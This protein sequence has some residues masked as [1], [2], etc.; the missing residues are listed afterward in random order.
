MLVYRF[1]VIS[2][3]FEDFS[4]EICI[5]PA[6]TF[7]EFHNCLMETAELLPCEQASFFLTDKKYKKN[8]EI[9]LNPV[10]RQVKRYDEEMDEMVMVKF[11][12]RLMKESKVKDFIEDPHQRLIYEYHGKEYFI[13]LLEL[14]KIMQSDG[15]GIYPKCVKRV[16]EIPKKKETFIVS[17]T[18]DVAKQ[19]DLD[20][21]IL[22]ELDTLSKLD[23]IEENDDELADIEEN[24]SDILF[25]DKKEDDQNQQEKEPEAKE[26]LSTE[27]DPKPSEDV[28]NEDLIDGMERLDDYE[29]I[30][31]IEIKYAKFGNDSNNE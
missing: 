7:L 12:P 2:E 3:E 4:R 8:K 28:G 23:G 24:L 22:P 13:F 6:Q 30:E 11:T 14:V 17:S 10:E 27:A 9:G 15:E 19:S 25:G 1:K 18:D 21:A 26:K 31:D 5:Q 16:G 29:N 20:D